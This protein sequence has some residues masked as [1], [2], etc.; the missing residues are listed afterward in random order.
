MFTNNKSE[1]KSEILDLLRDGQAGVELAA[2]MI[3][4]LPKAIEVETEKSYFDRCLHFTDCLSTNSKT[5]RR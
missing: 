3:A 5:T 1:P 2:D 4:S